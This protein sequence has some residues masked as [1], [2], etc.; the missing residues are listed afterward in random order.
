M[1]ISQ[2][3]EQRNALLTQIAPLARAEKLS[4]EQRS[5]YDAL[6][7]DLE[8][9]T[10][11]LERAQRAESIE[12]ELRS[13]TTNRPPRSNPSSNG[14]PNNA[15]AEQRAFREYIVKGRLSE[16]N[17]SHLRLEERDVMGSENT[18]AVIPSS[19]DPLLQ[20]AVKSSG[21]IANFVNVLN[22]SS[23]DPLKVADA[24]ASS[25]F[26]TNLTEGSATTPVNVPTSGK[27]V[28]ASTYTFATVV[29]N[30]LLQDSYFDLNAFISNVFGKVYAQT[31]AKHITLG[32]GANFDSLLSSAVSKVTTAG[33]VT[34]E[35]LIDLVGSL[36]DSQENGAKF[37]LSRKV[38][39]SLM[40]VKD[41]DG[42]YVLQADANGTP[43]NSILGFDIVRSPFSPDDS[44][45]GNRAVVLANPQN[46]TLRR[47]GG[48]GIIRLSE[49]G[50]LSLQTTF[51]GVYRAAGYTRVQTSNPSAV[52]L[53]IGAAS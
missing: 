53:T 45:V 31:L 22:T 26:F 44:T 16:E 41:G 18:T 9:L 14:D 8:T 38:W 11:D 2:I 24:D 21:G 1:K 20:I 37:I 42:R 13:A 23:G 43:Y 36:D 29:Q 4:P 3:N 7:S 48:L 6:V 51:M 28:G 52:A 40:K 50:A 39:A 46:Y 5:Q 15:E 12:Q 35:N 49:I 19:F 32:D 10:D 27:S 33:A 47:V 34:F 25:L 17:R 30:Q